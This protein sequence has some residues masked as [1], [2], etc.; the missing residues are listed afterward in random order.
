MIGVPAGG[1]RVMAFGRGISGLH[2][3]YVGTLSATGTNPSL[4]GA[5]NV[6]GFTPPVGVI[7]VKAELPDSYLMNVSPG[8]VTR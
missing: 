6:L 4:A 8:A 7:L 3:L 1:V 2:R 5:A